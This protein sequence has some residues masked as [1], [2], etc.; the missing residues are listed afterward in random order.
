MFRH[1]G[2]SRSQRQ[3]MVIAGWLASIAGAVNSSGFLLIGIFTSHVT[4]NVG[5][6]AEDAAAGDPQIVLWSLL[7][8]AYFAGAFV[9]SVALESNVVA[10]RSAIYAALLFGET[11]LLGGFLL[12]VELAAP[13][14]W[15]AELLCFAMGM[16]NSL[17][18]RLSGAV[19]RTT[20]LTG[21]V[22]DLGIEAAR[23]FRAWRGWLGDRTGIRLVAGD[24]AP[25]TPSSARTGVLVTI[26]IAFILGS[27]AGAWLASRVGAYALL[28]P[29]SG[30]FAAAL[31]AAYGAQLEARDA[32]SG[33][34]AS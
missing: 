24:G 17:V 14:K 25:V 27:I 7:V 3:N 6:L 34:I 31:Y 22:T 28:L 26:F 10:R 2:A 29:A 5:R 11:L 4:G 19:V 13:S 30:A 21:V 33:S 20:H 18:T 1:E 12:M 8:L 16:Q 15:E 9:A 32:G 23:W